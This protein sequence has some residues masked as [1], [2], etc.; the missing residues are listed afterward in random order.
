MRGA[1]GGAWGR[2]V[3][4]ERGQTSGVAGERLS[5]G[6]AR[7]CFRCDIVVVQHAA[8]LALA[9]VNVKIPRRPV[10]LWKP[11]QETARHSMRGGRCDL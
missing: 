3:R 5:Y 6:L 9:W 7:M 11:F 8:V 10:D 1:S 2:K 4:G